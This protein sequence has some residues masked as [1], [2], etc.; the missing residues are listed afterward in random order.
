M[1]SPASFA[2]SLTAVRG[3]ADAAGRP[4]ESVRGALFVWGTVDPDPVRARDEAVT[5][6][7]KLYAQDFEPLADRYLLHGDPDMVRVRLAEYEAAGA[8]T[9]IFSPACPPERVAAVT[10]LFAREVLPS[11]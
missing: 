5:A 10:E 4:P 9:V 7:S 11:L 3:F 2:R 1:V 6:V 8:G